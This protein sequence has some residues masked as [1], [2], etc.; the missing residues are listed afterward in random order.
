MTGAFH[1]GGDV[2]LTGIRLG[3]VKRT[4]GSCPLCSAQRVGQNCSYVQPIHPLR[5]V[6]LEAERHPAV[7]LLAIEFYLPPPRSGLVSPPRLTGRLATAPERELTPISD[8]V[9][10]GKTTLVSEWLYQIDHPTA[11]LSL[12]RDEN[13]LIRDYW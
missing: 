13:A 12:D 4:L 1:T 2:V 3:S 8:P 10:L 7:T 9:G 5:A 11:W 6:R